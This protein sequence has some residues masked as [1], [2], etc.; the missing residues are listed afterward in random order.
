MVAIGNGA[1][2]GGGTEL[3]PEADPE[4]GKLDVMVSPRRWAARQARLRRAGCAGAT[5]TSAT[6]SSTCAARR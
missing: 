4:D 3:T 1:S 5:T 6:T 2:V